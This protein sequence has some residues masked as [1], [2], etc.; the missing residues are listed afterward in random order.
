MAGYHR[1]QQDL[2]TTINVGLTLRLSIAF[3]MPDKD[4]LYPRGNGGMR[5]FLRIFD[6]E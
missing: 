5:P 2:G 1:F 3:I 6:Q 4:W